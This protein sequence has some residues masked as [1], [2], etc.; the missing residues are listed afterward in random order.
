MKVHN[1]CDCRGANYS[2]IVYYLIQPHY[3]FSQ[4]EFLFLFFFCVLYIF[5]LYHRASFLTFC[6][7]SH[8]CYDVLFFSS[9]SNPVTQL[10]PLPSIATLSVIAP[11]SRSVLQSNLRGSYP[12]RWRCGQGK[13]EKRNVNVE[14]VEEEEK[15]E[16]V[17]GEKKKETTSRKIKRV[18]KNERAREISVFQLV[19]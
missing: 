16:E 14:A 10:S 2:D 6:R 17:R 19:Y 7:S 4:K 1:L 8:S 13:R 9:F 11:S 3:H 5:L 18:K 12:C 15:Q